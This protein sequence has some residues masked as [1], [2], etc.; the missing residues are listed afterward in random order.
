MTVMRCLMKTW[1][2]CCRVVAGVIKFG[3]LE[4]ED[5]EWR[6][7]STAAITRRGIYLMIIY[8]MALAGF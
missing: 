2:L 1:W 5:R 4:C 8:D 7:L 3:S 6:T